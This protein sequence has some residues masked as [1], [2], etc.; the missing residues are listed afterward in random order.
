MK[1]LLLVSLCFLVLCVTQV[2]AQNRTV[3]GTVTSKDDGLPLPGVSVTV[4]GTKFGTQTNASGKFTLNAPATAQALSFSFIGFI[5]LDAPLGSGSVVNVSLASTSNQLGEV[6]VTGALGV[7]RQA[8]ELGY[9]ATNI[10]G[11]QLTETHPTNFTNGLTAKAPGLV[12]ST[13]NNGINPDTRFTLRGNRHIVGN[14]FAL[15][16][17]NGTPISPNEVQ[18]INPDDIESVNVLNGAGAAALYGSEASNGA[19]VITTKRGSSTSQPQITYSNTYQLETISYMPAL[20]SKFGGYGGEGAPFQDPVT[21]FITSNAPF[22][23]QSYGP[24]YDGH[25]QQLGIPLADGTIQSYPYA[26]PS[27]QSYARRF[28]QTGHSDQHSL[29][30]ASGDANNSFNLTAFRLDQTGVVPND[31]FNKTQIRVSGTKT[32][33]IFRAEAT[34]SFSQNNT[35]VY[36]N[37][38]DILSTIYNTPS[39]VPL[40]KFKDP[41]Q[42][43]SDP[44]TYFNSYGINPYWSI[45]NS[46]SKRRQDVFNGSFSGT[47]TPTKWMDATYRLAYNGG[48]YQQQD[49]RAQINFTAY[50][51]SDPTGGYSTVA[52]SYGAA[53]NPGTVSNYKGFGDGAGT[54]GYGGPQGYNRI[55]QDALVNFHKT[56]VNDHLK[57]NLLV[58]NSIWQEYA[59]YV[60]N[61]SNNLLVKD[62]YN[63][64]AILGVPNAA[65]GTFVIRQIAYFADLSL[66]WKDWAFLEGTIR[67]DHDSRLSAANRSIYYPSVKGSFVFTNAID[68]LKNNSIISYGKLRGGYSQVGDVNINPY[69]LVNTFNSTSGFPYGNLGALSQSTTLNNSNLKPELTSEVEVGTDL[70][71]FNGRVNLNATYYNTHTKNQTL[72]VAVSPTTGFSSTILNVGETQN[73]GY[74]FK[75]DV[76]ALPKTANGIGVNLGGNFSIQ[77]SKVL[78][79]FGDTKS[80]SLG[81]Y[82]IANTRAVVGQPYSVIYVTDINRDPQGRPI[83]NPVTGYP[84]LNPTLVNAGQTTPKYLLG[85]TQT[86]SYKFITLS[87]TEE[88]RGGNVIFSQSLQSATAAGVSQFSASSDRQRFIFPNSV[89]NTGTAANP[90]YTPNTTVSVNDGSL[91]FWDN[92]AFYQAGSTYISSGAF[93][94]LREANLNFDLSKFI[95]RTGFIKRASFSLNGRNLLMWRPKTNNWVDPEFANSS[96]NGDIGVNST[97]QLPPTRI[98]GGNITITF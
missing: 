30:Y 19:L 46:R 14:N 48:T 23:N 13:V 45:N 82:T 78:S 81:G 3:T 69:S 73:T 2:Y 87:L 56:F 11:K 59:D 29:S 89:I 28:F 21:G 39:W 94:K 72:P 35:D 33:G 24:A 88:Y 25:M 61:G 18:T 66:G 44:S 62:F 17:L 52:N 70:G 12:V 65:Q 47:L 74:E 50:A 42:P 38:G 92:G 84:S 15:V 58:G 43:F 83:V 75:L 85:L 55:Q 27:G 76:T 57:A 26:S 54:I 96:G 91:G 97:N 4:K 77:N 64:N 60:S 79:L 41:T 86:I 49:R 90:V 8:K 40:Q 9:A 51:L 93:W 32:A 1:K 7:K 22:E 63:V 36:G 20:Q 80:L 53:I 31:K 71:F 67:N 34:G 95:K 98:F 68:A 16:V 10:G 5:K 37:Y 6:V